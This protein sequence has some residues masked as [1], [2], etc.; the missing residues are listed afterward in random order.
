MG[1]LRHRK[2]MAIAFVLNSIIQRWNEWNSKPFDSTLSITLVKDKSELQMN[3]SCLD[4][5]K[6]SLR[7]EQESFLLL[8]RTQWA[9]AQSTLTIIL[10][11]IFGTQSLFSGFVYA[12]EHA[13]KIAVQKARAANEENVLSLSEA[14]ICLL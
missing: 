2:Y 10:S 6:G 9:R 12:E 14:T 13:Q 11:L 8:K 1:T 4:E 3:S 5:T 7:C